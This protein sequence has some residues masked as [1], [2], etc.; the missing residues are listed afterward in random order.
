MIIMRPVCGST[1]AHISHCPLG[2]RSSCPGYTQA[3][4]D[5]YALIQLVYQ[6]AALGLGEYG[7]LFP[8]VKMVCHPSVAND[9][10]KMV[11]PMYTDFVGGE[12]PVQ[13]LIECVTDASLPKGSW[14]IVIGEGVIGSGG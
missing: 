3:E 2:W 13:S 14:R 1:D 12:D 11:I 6:V 9:I 5:T 4:H 10:M 8:D 7:D